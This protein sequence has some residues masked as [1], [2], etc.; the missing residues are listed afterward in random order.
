MFFPEPTA[1]LYGWLL[2]TR[3]FHVVHFLCLSNTGHMV[4][5]MQNCDDT[6]GNAGVMICFGQGGLCSLSTSSCLCQGQKNIVQYM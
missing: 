4:L 1:E 5:L 2:A 6:V 3:Y